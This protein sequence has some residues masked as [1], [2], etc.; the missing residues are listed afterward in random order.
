[1]TSS[2]TLIPKDEDSHHSSESYSQR[3]LEC[4]PQEEHI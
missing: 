3:M 2:V 4:G 1:M